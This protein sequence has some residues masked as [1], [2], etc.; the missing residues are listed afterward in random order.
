MPKNYNS[1]SDLAILASLGFDLAQ[2]RHALQRNEFDLD[3]AIDFL[4]AESIHGSKNIESKTWLKSNST[5]PKSK[6][7]LGQ[8]VKH[9][10][11]KTTGK[12]AST[13]ER[14]G[15]QLE[16]VP[17]E[18]EPLPVEF[19]ASL[20]E[21]TSQHYKLLNDKIVAATTKPDGASNGKLQ[22]IEDKSG[23]KKSD[24]NTSNDKSNHRQH[25]PPEESALM[26]ST[27]RDQT[28]PKN[29]FKMQEKLRL[30]PAAAAAVTDSHNNDEN[31]DG[32]PEI[33][34]NM[35]DR[36]DIT[37]R[38]SLG[39]QAISSQHS[40]IFL[41]EQS[42]RI[43]FPVEATVV[44]SQTTMDTGTVYDGVCINI[45]ECQTTQPDH[46][47][48]EENESNDNVED[49][50]NTRTSQSDES[51]PHPI[52]ENEDDNSPSRRR[53]CWLKKHPG[54]FLFVI[55]FIPIGAVR[56]LFRNNDINDP[57]NSEVILIDTNTSESVLNETFD[58]RDDDE[59][60]EE[61]NVTLVEEFTTTLPNDVF[62]SSQSLLGTTI[63][64][65][66]SF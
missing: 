48:R 16:I 10:A 36:R 37:S 52:D 39:R 60:M 13:K 59:N 63:A 40:N 27:N 31:N 44:P 47:Q 5:L 20:D 50:E 30:H 45:D 17:D 23:L 11:K 2:S 18:D 15:L 8:T 61:N 62:L 34:N 3:R 19:I 46:P 1:D 26:H 64:M 4:I 65:N 49:S 32:S 57:S 53:S 7:L 42:R 43:Y 25:D 51:N 21:K 28:S 29:N 58:Y 54:I 55:A 9:T 33:A 6:A 12:L 38:D 66:N 56:K 14:N 41:N 24:T 35:S 22:N